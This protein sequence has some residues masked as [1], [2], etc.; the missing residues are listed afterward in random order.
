MTFFEY[1]KLTN[2]QHVLPGLEG[3]LDCLWDGISP[4]NKATHDVMLDGANTIAKT[5]K[6]SKFVVS[7]ILSEIEPIYCKSAVFYIH[8]SLGRWLGWNEWSVARAEIQGKS[9]E[10]IQLAR[11]QCILNLID[12]FQNNTQW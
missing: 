4:Y 11:K 12:R 3:V 5:D 6:C 10:V 2:N 8:D 9:S 7:K 1:C